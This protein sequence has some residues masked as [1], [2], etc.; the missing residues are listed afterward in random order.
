M[1]DNRRAYY[2]ENRTRIRLAAK[3]RRRENV[4]EAILHD[5]RQADRKR[6]RLN[7]LDLDLVREAVAE[8][9]RYCGETTL[10]MTLDRIDNSLGHT[11]ANVV[12]ACE[13]CNYARRDMPYAAWLVVAIAM[14]QAREQGLFGAWTGGIHRRLVL[15]PTPPSPSTL[16]GPPEHGTLARYFKCGPPRCEECRRAMREWKRGRREALAV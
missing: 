12:P 1:T 4:A 11:K 7:D 8:P 2:K 14:R 9:C 16:R 3:N 13:R 15:D 6:G 5:A 10:R